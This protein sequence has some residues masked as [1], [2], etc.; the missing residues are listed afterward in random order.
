MWSAGT[1]RLTIR[2]L[3]LGGTWGPVPRGISPIHTY[4]YVIVPVGESKSLLRYVNLSKATIY[5]QIFDML[6]YIAEYYMPRR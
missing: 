3:F 1:D 2:D 4:E 6:R 5:S